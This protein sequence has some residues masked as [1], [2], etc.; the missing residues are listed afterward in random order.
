MI[1]WPSPFRLHVHMATLTFTPLSQVIMVTQQV[2][3]FFSVCFNGYNTFH[4]II[5]LIHNSF[6]NISATSW[7]VY[8][9]LCLRRDALFDFLITLV[10]YHLEIYGISSFF[11]DNMTF[12]YLF[13]KQNNIGFK[14]AVDN[15]LWNFKIHEK[16]KKYIE[17]L[18]N[19]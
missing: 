14:C 19:S 10:V 18:K 13:F 9:T 4:S 2:N 15:C 6:S 17:K 3:T 1:Q 5:E 11:T 8:C 16:M 7:Q 12:W